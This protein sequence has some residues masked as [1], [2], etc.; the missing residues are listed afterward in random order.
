MEKVTVEGLDAIFAELA[1]LDQDKE[2]AEDAMKELNK[3]INQLTYKAA[4]YLK[5]LGRSEYMSPAG[6][7]KVELAE[8]IN[9]P[10]TEEARAALFAHLRARGI[11]DGIVKPNSQSL[12]A[13][14][15]ADRRAA[16]QAAPDEDKAMVRMTFSMP[17]IGEVKCEEKP[18]F[19]PTKKK[20]VT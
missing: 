9:L 18:K 11:F 6:S 5:D 2:V 20:A 15:F 13:L 19:K 12:N 8:R 16:I 17:G 10:D 7:M 1:K 4:A 14:Y 3:S